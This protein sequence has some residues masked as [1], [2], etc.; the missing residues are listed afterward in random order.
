MGRKAVFLGIMATFG[1]KIYE[2]R[3]FISRKVGIFFAI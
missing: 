3:S 1:R 2:E